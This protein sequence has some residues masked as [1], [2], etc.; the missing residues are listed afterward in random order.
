MRL[1][2]M[3]TGPFAVPSF[4]AISRRG[5]EIVCV[6]T[7]PPIS[8]ES[9]KQAQ[10][11]SPVVAWAHHQN[12]FIEW[13]DSIN[14]PKSID[15]LRSYNADLMV[16]CDY[17]QILSKEALS[18]ARLGGINLHGSLL[19]RHRGAAPVQWAILAG[20]ELAGVSVIHMTV[21]LDGGPV[22]ARAATPIETGE[23]AGQLEV[24]LSQLGIEPV[25][26]SLKLLESNSAIDVPIQDSLLATK[27][28]RLKKQDG[29][30]HFGYPVEWIDRQIRGLQPWPGAYG[31]VHF[32]DGKELRVQVHKARPVPMSEEW[33]RDIDLPI[34]IVLFGKQ[35][36]ELNE[37]VGLSVSGELAVV[38][39]NGLLFVDQLQP[40]GKR[41]QQADEFVR[42]Y[43]RYESFSFVTPAEPQALLE[44]IIKLHMTHPPLRRS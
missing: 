31:M 28:P 5:D 7:R 32:P 20:D 9:R 4:D 24:R 11:N 37:R 10:P 26:H 14:D 12:R 21:A 1:I 23:D 41:T 19:P 13:P 42:G 29:Q 3:G 2:L 17:G 6:I 38:A 43:N 30:L 44:R 25:L 34:G 18:T 33:M 27:A 16:V 8:N 40:A 22:V 15:M 39:L 35:L 36:L